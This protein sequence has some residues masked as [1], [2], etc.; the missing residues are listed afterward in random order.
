M[1]G[2]KAGARDSDDVLLVLWNRSWW[3][4]LLGEVSK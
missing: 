4:E 3:W 2:K 1:K